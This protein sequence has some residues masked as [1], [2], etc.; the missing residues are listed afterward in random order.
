MRENK[1]ASATE[2][3]LALRVL[4]RRMRS[5]VPSEAHE[6]TWSQK[7]V[8][9]RLDAEGPTT[10]AELARAEGVKPQSMSA[11][12]AALEGLGIVERNPHPTDGRQMNVALT[13]KGSHLRKTSRIASR[14]WLADAIA[15]L[16]ASERKK[17]PAVT[18]L[19]KRLGES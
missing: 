1:D 10:V 9:V 5:T 11:T 14:T 19:L 15:Q 3:A 6:L 16:D 2:L 13:A 12:V 7:A 4:V 8:M 18:A 17:L